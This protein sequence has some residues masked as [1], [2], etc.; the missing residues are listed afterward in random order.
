MMLVAVTGTVT[1]TPE[2]TV[3]VAMGETTGV[4]IGLTVT[5]LASA[6]EL[7]FGVTEVSVAV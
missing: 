7:K 5:E 6:A 4:G 2:A 1:S 3:C